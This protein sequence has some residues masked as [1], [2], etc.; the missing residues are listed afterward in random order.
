M[1]SRT[2]A[3]ATAAALLSV[4]ACTGSGPAQPAAAPVPSASA[5]RP[6][7]GYSTTPMVAEPVFGSL[8]GVGKGAAGAAVKTLIGYVRADRYAPRRMQPKSAYAAADFAGPAEHMTP[9]LAKWWRKQVAGKYATG[10]TGA[11][12]VIATF[13]VQGPADN[14]FAATGPLVVNERIS[15][16]TVSG[17]GGGALKI[18]LTYDADLR[19]LDTVD[20]G[21]PILVPVTKTV[22]YTM[23]KSR[24][25]WL[26]DDFDGSAEVGRGK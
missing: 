9:G 2:A 1:P 11:V 24:G 22:T 18:K 3:G 7:P 21:R 13:N 16:P 14:A 19:M 20:V 4:A 8:R 15:R 25:T 12:A 6:E 23:V 5:P 17:T 10:S 26:I